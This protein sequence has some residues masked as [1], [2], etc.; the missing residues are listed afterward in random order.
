[1]TLDEMKKKLERALTP[2]RYAHSINV[3]KTAVELAEKYQ[4]DMGSAAVAGLLHDCARD[5]RGDELFN[6]CSLNGVEVDELLRKQPELLHGPLGAKM[7]ATEYD[8]HDVAI[9][10][11]IA[12]HTTGKAGMGPLDKIIFVADYIEPGRSFPGVQEV[13]QLAFKDLDRALLTALDRTVQHVMSKEALV[14]PGTIE[15]RNHI[16]LAGTHR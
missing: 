14:H 5:V 7:A 10:G 16:L 3:M 11:A 12:C 1:M 15:A 6:L 9:L 2:K 4:I 8:I 13:R